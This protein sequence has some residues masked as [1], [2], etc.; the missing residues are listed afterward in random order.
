MLLLSSVVSA[1]NKAVVPAEKTS[2]VSAAKT[3]VVSDISI[4]STPTR[5]RRSRARVVVDF[6]EMSDTTDVLAA[7]KEDTTDVLAADTTDVFSADTTAFL[8]ADTTDD[9]N[10]NNNIL[11]SF[12]D[13]FGGTL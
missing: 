2:V 1:D 10:D 11:G 7:D 8:S 3:S 4:S 9:N 12:W 5:A 13:H 6:I